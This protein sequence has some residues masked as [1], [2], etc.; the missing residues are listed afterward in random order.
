MG[1]VID[2]SALVDAYTKWYS[3]K[4]IPT[5]WDRLEALADSGEATVP[6]AVLLELEVVDDGLYR[7]CK[8]R[9]DAMVT[10]TTE[11]IQAIVT[12]ISTSYPALRNAGAPGR[13]FADPIVIALA[14]YL[15]FSVVT[16]ELATGNLNGPRIPDV[17][18]DKGISVMQVH[19]MVR[20]LGWTFS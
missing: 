7:W 20:E 5:F 13:N 8:D 16:H 9:E 1:Y 6:D 14:E 15:D 18:R 2:T 11:D 12:T 3:P 10:P 4:S 19:H 17:C